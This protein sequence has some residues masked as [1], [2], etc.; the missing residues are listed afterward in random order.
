LTNQ[1]PIKLVTIKPRLPIF[2]QDDHKR[3]AVFF[4]VNDPP[5]VRRHKKTVLYV[6]LEFKFA[7]EA[8]YIHLAFVPLRGYLLYFVE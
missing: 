6:D 5:N 8:G 7:L 3:P 4:R 2:S 1:G